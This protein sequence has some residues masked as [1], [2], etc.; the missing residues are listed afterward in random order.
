MNE[1][2]KEWPYELIMACQQVTYAPIHDDMRNEYPNVWILFDSLTN[3]I[4]HFGH[5]STGVDQFNE[6]LD[7][8]E[9]VESLALLQVFDG[10]FEG[11]D[12]ERLKLWDMLRPGVKLPIAEALLRNQMDGVLS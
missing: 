11:D 10:F 7:A 2:D 5:S 4:R 9:D 6:C 12:V 8:S 3:E 1:N